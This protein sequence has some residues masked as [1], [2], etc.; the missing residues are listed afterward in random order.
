MNGR[1]IGYLGVSP[2]GINFGV[3]PEASA[4]TSIL[5]GLPERDIKTWHDELATPV[6]HASHVRNYLQYR[7]ELHDIVREITRRRREDEARRYNKGVRQ[8]V[9]KIGS[10]VMLYQKT[11]GK[12]QSRWR[13]PF[14]ITGYG[15]IHGHSFTLRQLVTERG[16]RDTFHGDHLKTFIPRIGYLADSTMDQYESD[17]TIRRPRRQQRQA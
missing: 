16:I 14:Q 3:V 11:S 7:A 2:I 1:T 17:Q 9:H 10:L 5:L 6:T 13:E 8:V 4:V 12:L 15:G